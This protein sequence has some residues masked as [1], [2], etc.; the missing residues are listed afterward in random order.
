MKAAVLHAKRDLRVEERPQP[1]PTGTQVLIRVR[2][3][4]VC[5][6]DVHYYTEMRIGDQVIA[7]PQAVGHEF[8]G[9]VAAVG[10]KVEHFKVGD[11]ICVEPGLSCGKCRQCRE[12]RPNCC[13]NV[14]FY[15]TPP[16]EG[17]LQEFVLADQEQCTLLPAGMSFA[18]AAMLEPL[19]V[20]VHAFNLVPCVPGDWVAIVGAGSIGLSCLAM[21]RAAGATRIIVTDKLDYRLAL[22]KKLGATHTVN[23]ERE[24]ALAAVKKITD[25]QGA[26]VVYEAT[27]SVKGLPQAVALARIAGRVAA[28]G[29]PPVDE[30]PLPASFPRRK[31][32][33]VQFIRRSAHSIRQALELV[34]T[35]KIDVKPWITHRFPLARVKEAFDLV[36][37]YGDGV[38]KTVIE[39]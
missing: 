33:T 7:K 31:Q 24:D 19:Q 12:G 14:I 39:M 36:D 22:A 27:N 29:I 21:V 37:A 20:G 38:L 25:G 32:L 8:A 9:E 18:E 11:R 16:V 2:A 28:I 1:S 34:A 30:I 4:G 3:V 6:S 23:V 35:G 26:D 15:G 13:P 17:A 10:P 5:G